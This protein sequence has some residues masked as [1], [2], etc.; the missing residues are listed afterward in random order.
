M[1]T[2]LIIATDEPNPSLSQRE[3]A[4]VVLEIDDEGNGLVTKNRNGCTDL[5]LESEEPQQWRNFLR[6]LI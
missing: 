3:A 4:D 6:A 2:L 1:T 5:S